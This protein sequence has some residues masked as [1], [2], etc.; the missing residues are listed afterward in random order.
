VSKNSVRKSRRYGDKSLYFEKLHKIIVRDPV[1]EYS[2]VP[3]D[4]ERMHVRRAL[5]NE[6][7][8]ASLNATGINVSRDFVNYERKNHPEYAADAEYIAAVQL[9]LLRKSRAERGSKQ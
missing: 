4:G 2:L 8:R 7:V 3:A 1:P 9:A 5:A 6:A